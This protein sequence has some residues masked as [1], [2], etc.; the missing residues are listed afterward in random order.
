[1]AGRSRIREGFPGQRLTVLSRE[2][3]ERCRRLPVVRDLHV[4]DLGHFP[5]AAGH[6]VQRPRP[7]PETILIYCADGA[8]WC[9]M[10]GR[11]RRVTKGR[12]LFIPEGVPHTYGAD[13]RTPWSIYW[14]HFAGLRAADYR[15]ALGVSVQ[16]PL[17]HVP[18][19]ARVIEAFEEMVGH[20]RGGWTDASLLSLSTA[21]G[22]F[23]GVLK[24][25][26][27]ALHTRGRRA[28]EKVLEA[29]RF[30]RASLARPLRLGDLAAHVYL[31]PSHF[32]ALFRKQT[33]MS[34]LKFF[35][36]LRMQQACAALDS[37]D[38]L[39]SQVGE[40]LGYDD[41]FY[42]SRCFAR[43][44][45]LSPARYRAVSGDRSGRR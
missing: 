7:R 35:T 5:A 16:R 23:L 3:A 29:I 27:R 32:S 8:G 30:M 24:A 18:D 45:G 26:Q 38:L 25:H 41:P 28:Q 39:V 42:F 10:A 6:Y 37:T 15:A 14:V 22:R 34:P 31:S 9:R 43:T 13:R 4:T 36:R 44:M 20:A 12:A 2:V 17:L 21:L 11:R 19:T 33:N 1:V 40:G